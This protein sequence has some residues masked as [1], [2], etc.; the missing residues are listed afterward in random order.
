MRGSVMDLWF[1]PHTNEK[2]FA[3]PGT[4]P[5][6]ASN[7]ITFVPAT[8]VVPAHGTAKVKLVVT[9]PPDAD[10]G[11]YAVLFVESKPEL[12]RAASD[13]QRPI[14]A[15]LRLGALVLLSAAATE[16]FGLAV[17]AVSLTPPGEDRKLEMTIELTNTSNTHIF[18][19][20]RLAVLDATRKVIARAEGDAKR[21]FPGQQD[22][23]RL[24]WAGTLAPG[25]Y[26][27][28]LTIAYG[29]DKVHTEER[30]LHVAP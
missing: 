15:N 21:F 8:F 27:T 26:T 9:P 30:P 6:S 11:S 4:L 24:T 17:N 5:R 7:W 25:D 23:I 29:A 28:V 16:R 1:D 12:A 3:P 19:Q 2:V 13:G 10:G 22:T 18:P 14:F 20:A